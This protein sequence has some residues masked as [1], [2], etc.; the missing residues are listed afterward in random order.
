MKAELGFSAADYFS[1]VYEKIS[2]VGV[3][4]EDL[5]GRFS[6]RPKPASSARPFA[7]NIRATMWAGDTS[8]GSGYNTFDGFLKL[9]KGLVTE[10]SIYNS[11]YQAADLENNTFAVELFDE[12]WTQADPR[13]SNTSRPTDSSPTS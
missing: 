2:I 11:T 13:A 10:Q 9:I 3:N 7:E 6:N 5:S 1:M 4:M 8:A 12:L